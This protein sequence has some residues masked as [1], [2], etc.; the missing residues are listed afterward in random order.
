MIGVDDR[1][2]TLASSPSDYKRDILFFDEMLLMHSTRAINEW[3]Y[4]AHNRAKYQAFA[5]EME[6]LLESPYFFSSD[7]LVGVPISGPTVEEIGSALRE[8]DK[9]LQVVLP[10]SSGLTV[11]IEEFHQLQG[12]RAS[13]ST[14]LAAA[15]LNNHGTLAVSAHTMPLI[16][17]DAQVESLS[18]GSVLHLAIKRVLIP[19]ERTSWEDIFALKQDIGLRDRARKLR[20]WASKIAESETSPATVEEQLADLLSDYETYLRAHKLKYDTMTLGAIVV[21]GAE[22]IEDVAKL[23][24]GKLAAKLFSA[25][26]TKAEMTLSEMQAPGRELSIVTHLNRKLA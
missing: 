4:G 5:D 9:R 23:R 11:P 25:S 12:L 19:E 16:A 10:P 21:L 1:S 3:R 24:L 17:Q 20:L 14:R 13:L 7:R 26:K 18:T 15:S 6:F 22:L 2:L 8:V